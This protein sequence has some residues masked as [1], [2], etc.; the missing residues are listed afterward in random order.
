[1][2]LHELG[3]RLNFSL[4]K[5]EE[6]VCKGNVVYHEYI[7]RTPGE[8]K[9][10]IDG[11][12]NKRDLKE[13]RKKDQDENVRRKAEKRGEITAADDGEKKEGD[14]DDVKDEGDDK[15]VLGKRGREEKSV[16]RTGRTDKKAI[17]KTKTATVTA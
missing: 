3:P 10:Q 8:V 13:K 16:N 14:D 12:K 2:R 5:I 9:K 4:V 6:G 7:K 11:I 17:L 15:R 1:L